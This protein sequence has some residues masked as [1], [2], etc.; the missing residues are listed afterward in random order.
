MI[1][2]G[3]IAVIQSGQRLKECRLIGVFPGAEIVQIG[4]EIPQLCI[5]HAQ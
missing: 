4:I 2:R 1:V 5:Y 3:V